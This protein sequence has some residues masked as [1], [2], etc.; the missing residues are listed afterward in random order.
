MY[1]VSVNYVIF[2]FYSSLCGDTQIVTQNWLENKNIC[3]QP[4]NIL[5]N[6]LRLLQMLT[7]QI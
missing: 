1:T 2:T 7:G 5:Y 4:N 3:T 6:M